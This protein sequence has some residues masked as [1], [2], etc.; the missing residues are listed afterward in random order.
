MVDREER[1]AS[2]QMRR[3]VGDFEL[4]LCGVAIFAEIDVLVLL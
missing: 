4:N 1:A 3:M 2:L